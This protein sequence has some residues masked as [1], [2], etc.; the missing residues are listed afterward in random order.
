MNLT[1]VY[2]HR[3]YLVGCIGITKEISNVTDF[4]NGRDEII[5]NSLEN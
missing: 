2:Y 4:L 5:K 1:L 3:R